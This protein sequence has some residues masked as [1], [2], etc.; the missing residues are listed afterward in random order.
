MAIRSSR[1]SKRF[2]S[3]IRVRRTGKHRRSI[4]RTSLRSPKR[5]TVSQL[6]T[7]AGSGYGA[8]FSSE[9]ELGYKRGMIDGAERL[10]EK[11]LPTDAIIPG[12]TATEAMAAGVQALKARALPLLGMESVFEEL[13]D[14]IRNRRPYAFV[15]LGDGELM[16]LAQNVVLPVSEVRASSPYLPYAGIVVPD[17]EARDELARIIRSVNLVGVPISRQ[18]HFQP[19][20]FRVFQAH[21]I[22]CSSLKLTTST[23]N[24]AL[25]EHGYLQRLIAGRR[26]LLVGNVAAELAQAL[27]AQG[28][29][30]AGIVC[31]VKGYP[32]VGRVVAEAVTHDFDLAI[33]SAGIPAVP[34]VARIAELTGKVAIDFGHLA[35]QIAGIKTRIAAIQ[36]E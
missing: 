16:T 2:R 13:E 17:L 33:V 7:N 3:K 34:I 25:H 29:N 31:P 4:R 19:L 36:S 8:S 20:L 10:L 22:A 1:Q 6:P 21:G 15:R 26:L 35:D 12:I 5:K 23:M 11:H 32:D 28:H 18:P 27:K 14:A 30:V 9:Y 24:Y